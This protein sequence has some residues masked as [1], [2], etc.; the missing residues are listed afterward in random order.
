MI[1]YLKELNFN[2]IF[3]FNDLYLICDNKTIEYIIYFALYITIL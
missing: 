1:F 2:I 3:Y